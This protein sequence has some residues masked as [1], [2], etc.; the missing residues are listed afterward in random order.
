MPVPLFSRIAIPFGVE[1]SNRVAA[2]FTPS[3]AGSIRSM[4]GL[5]TVAGDATN[6][7]SDARPEWHSARSAMRREEDDRGADETDG[8]AAHVPTVGPRALDQPQPDQG[9][10]N[11]DAAIGR[12]GATL[13][14]DLDQ[15]QQPGERRQRQHARHEPPGRSAQPQP[16]P[17]SEAS[18]DL[19]EGGADIG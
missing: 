7:R 4:D 17:E 8:R 3:R 9:C 6:A 10:G 2:S 14:I 16:G 19:E 11:V 15:R 5:S 18:A 1:G 12:V 13:D